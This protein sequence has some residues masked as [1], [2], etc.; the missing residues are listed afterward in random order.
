M[1]ELMHG[2]ITRLEVDA[3]VCPAHKYL[4]KGQGL[5][6]QIH[7]L[8]GPELAQACGQAEKCPAGH[9][10][11]TP[12]FNLPCRYIIHTV[13][14]LWT[15][16]D[17]WGGATLSQLG[18]CFRNSL[19]LAQQHQLKTIAFPALGAGSNRTPHA[20][21]AHEGLEILQPAA[22]QFDRLIVCLSSAVALAEWQQTQQKFFSVS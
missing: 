6:A 14:P 5:S 20:I 9:A 13:T 19:A 8:A 21:V 1:I 22:A 11:I 15:G 12:A 10:V 4:S 3:I 7:E 2:D 16:G 18:D 17:Q